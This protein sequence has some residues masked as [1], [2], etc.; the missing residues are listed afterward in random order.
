M[1]VGTHPSILAWKIPCME[2]PSRVDFM[3]HKVS[4]RIEPTH[5]YTDIL[6][7]QEKSEVREVVTVQERA[8]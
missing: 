1:E 2:G 8:R 6:S 7:I 3:G 4:D 5:T